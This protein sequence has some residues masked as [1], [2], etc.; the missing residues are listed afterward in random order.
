[1]SGVGQL[2]AKGITFFLIQLQISILNSN[3][4]KRYNDKVLIDNVEFAKAL[5]LG[6]AYR[7]NNTKN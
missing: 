2:F 4:F 5:G 6:M 3:G 7:Q 1:M